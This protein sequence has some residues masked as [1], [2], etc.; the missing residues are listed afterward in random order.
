[1]SISRE[2]VSI[3]T[4][5]F[6]CDRLKDELLRVV[7]RVGRVTDSERFAIRHDHGLIEIGESSTTVLFRNVEFD[8][9]FEATV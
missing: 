8:G 7:G 2:E 5:V 1:V 4:I 3:S 6:D 9:T